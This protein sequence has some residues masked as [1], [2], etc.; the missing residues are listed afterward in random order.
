[1]EGPDYV[2]N[3][4]RD[5]PSALGHYRDNLQRDIEMIRQFKCDDPLK[6]PVLVA[7]GQSDSLVSSNALFEWKD[8]LPQSQIRLFPGD[9][10]YWRHE[11][12]ALENWIMSNSGE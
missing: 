6:C 2:S 11:M 7:G 4:V 3:A 9:H 5:S 10:F 8:Y 1:M 12:K